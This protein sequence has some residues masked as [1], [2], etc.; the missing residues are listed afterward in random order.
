MNETDTKRLHE[1][2]DQMIS[3][4]LTTAERAEYDTLAE[5]WNDDDNAKRNGTGRYFT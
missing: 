5:R 4:K 2:I 3:G 1:L